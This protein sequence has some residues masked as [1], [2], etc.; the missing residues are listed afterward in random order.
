MTANGRTVAF[1]V[2]IILLLVLSASG[3]QSLTA[4]NAAATT[5]QKVT[6]ATQ[7][8][9]GLAGLLAAAGLLARRPWGRAAAWLWAALITLTAGLAPVVRGGAAPGLGLA[10]AL[11]VAALALLVMSLTARRVSPH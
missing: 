10:S 3:F 2:G 4:F 7:L 8:A 9:Y 5:G 11:A 1:W 6:T